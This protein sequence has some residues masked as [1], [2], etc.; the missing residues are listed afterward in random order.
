MC[1]AGWVQANGVWWGLWQSQQSPRGGLCTSAPA[2]CGQVEFLPNVARVLLLLLLL[3]CF[4]FK[5]ESEM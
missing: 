2:D 4:V 3:F 5:E 1:D